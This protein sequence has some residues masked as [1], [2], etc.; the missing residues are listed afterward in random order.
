MLYLE[1]FIGII[2]PATLWP[3]RRAESLTWPVRT[4]DSI[5]TFMC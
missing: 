2:L 4:A 1:F 3:V 5:T